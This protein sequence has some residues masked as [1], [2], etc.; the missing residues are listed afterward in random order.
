[1][2]FC[3]LFHKP[4]KDEPQR[5][6]REDILSAAERCFVRSGF[7]RSTMQDVAAEARMSAGNVYRYFASKSAIVAG[8]VA[9]DRAEAASDFETLSASDPLDAFAS[10]LRRRMVE[11]GRDKAA[12]WLEICS[13]ASRNPDVA[14]VTRAYETEIHGRLAECF[15]SV[16]DARGP[17]GHGRIGTAEALARLVL[18]QISGMMVTR[19][20]PAGAETAERDVGDLMAIVRAVVDGRMSLGAGR[21]LALEAAEAGL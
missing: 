12:L 10:L 3:S 16:I 17:G 5:Q 2:A 21:T 13:E 7:H 15:Q 20:M 14:E 6:R 8:L 11:G 9:R 18:S 19:A 1:M 4:A